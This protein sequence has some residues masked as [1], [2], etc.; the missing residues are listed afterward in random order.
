[1]A[2]ACDREG[3]FRA[4]IVSYGLK[5]MESG[6]VS[7]ALRARLTEFW[8]GQQWH[9]WSDYDMESEG[10]VWIIKKSGDVNLGQA[11]ALMRFAGWD[12]NMESIVQETWHPSPVQVAVQKD[13]YKGSVRY[14]IAFIND[15]NRTPGALS[16]VSKDKA[17]ELQAKFGSQF[18]AIAS[19]VQRNTQAPQGRP[20]APRPFTPPDSREVVHSSGEDIPF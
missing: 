5:E 12:G 16:N 17:R 15:Y 20:Q 7:V 9:P 10:D 3:H 2:N 18:R 13:E 6:A 19:N 11:E 14:K 4:T 1:M 8:D